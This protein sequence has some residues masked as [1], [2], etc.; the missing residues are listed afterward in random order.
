MGPPSGRGVKAAARRGDARTVT[1]TGM[2]PP[3]RAA[4]LVLAAAVVGAGVSAHAAHDAIERAHRATVDEAQRA[5]LR[6]VS[7]EARRTLAAAPPAPAAPP[8]NDG[9]TAKTCNGPDCPHAADSGGEHPVGHPRSRRPARRKARKRR[10]KA[11]AIRERRRQVEASG[12]APPAQPAAARPTRPSMQARLLQFLAEHPTIDGVRVRGDDGALSFAGTFPEGAYRRETGPVEVVATDPAGLASATAMAAIDERFALAS[13]V[14]I[15]LVGF[16]A[17][18]FRRRLL[19][20]SEVA[21]GVAAGRFDDLPALSGRDEFRWIA[22]T[23]R[24]TADLVREQI[25]RVH[26]RNAHLVRDLALQGDHLARLTRCAALLVSPVAG[27]D[28]LD[29][30]FSALVEDTDACLGVLFEAGSD[31]ALVPRSARGMPL[32]AIRANAPAQRG[33]LAAAGRSREVSTHPAWTQAHPWMA[34][35]GRVVPLEGVV[36]VGLRHRGRL[37][38]LLVLAARHPFPERELGFLRDVARPFAIAMANRR[39]Y[40]TQRALARTLAERNDELVRQRDELRALDRLRNQFV[41]NISHE[42]RTPLGA[43]VGYAELLADEI[44]GPIN[45]EQREA[46][47]GILET[48]AHLLQL[49]NQ[50]L[51]LSKA[52]HEIAPEPRPVDARAVAEEAARMCAHL[53]KTRPYDIVVSGA[54]EAPIVS[55]PE[56]VRQILVNLIGNAVKFTPEG[57]VR[58]EVERSDDGGVAIHVRDSGRGIAPEHA[59]LVFEAFRQVDQSSTRAA[60]GAGLGLAISRRIARCLGGDLSLE[61]RPGEG[62][63]FTLHLPRAC[64]RPESPLEPAKEAA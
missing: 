53:T 46:L 30:A 47:E 55:D 18:R 58:V 13:T 37:E 61:S 36:T 62:S 5:A 14:T 17:L 6:L 38:G 63:T 7:D 45:D 24:E 57:W 29:A 54:P 19:V 2:A 8:E 41:A 39:A 44:Y 33:W 3:S 32:A 27:D 31:G 60:D 16:V 23:L 35:A 49:V 28:G 43:V 12:P 34:A 48:A 15:V 1:P 22:D 59:E 21:Q 52:D 64:P 50:V 25:E 20:L 42:L 51:D 10:A 26:G 11:K 4:P 40:H 9:A 56:Y